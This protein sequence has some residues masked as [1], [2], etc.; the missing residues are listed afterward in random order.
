[1]KINK[2]LVEE[3]MASFIEHLINH[4]KAILGATGAGAGGFGLYELYNHFH[5]HSD[6]AADAASQ[7]IADQAEAAKQDQGLWDKTKQFV[8]DHPYATGAVGL[9]LGYGGYRLATRR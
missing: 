3:S 1:M 9:G 7:K 4:K 6:N 5:N 8:S 2:K